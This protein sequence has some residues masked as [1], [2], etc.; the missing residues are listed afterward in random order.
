MPFEITILVN[1]IDKLKENF[2]KGRF[3]DALVS[4]LN[5]GNGLMQQRIFQANKDIN[6]NSF[7]LYIGKKRKARLQVSKNKTQNKRNKNVAGQDLTAYQRKRLLKGRSINPKNLEFTG[8]LRLSI[9]TQIGGVYYP[10]TSGN[11]T[12]GSQEKTATLEFNNDEAALI[13]KGQEAQISN[14]RG[15]GKGTTKGI[16]K[17]IFTLDQSEREQVNEQARELIMQILK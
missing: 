13:S 9:E 11:I 6:G 4:S 17:R 7:G 1:K 10:L 12:T 15:G 2:E 5:T 8:G 14:I 16:G 3:G